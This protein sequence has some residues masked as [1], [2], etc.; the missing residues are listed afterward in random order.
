[1]L[2][3]FLVLLMS[4]LTQGQ[5]IRLDE[6]VVL[7]DMRDFSNRIGWRD[8]DIASCSLGAQIKCKTEGT[9]LLDTEMLVFPLHCINM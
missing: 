4:L 6:Q 3:L 5:E 8:E 9:E 1:M 7:K 2:C